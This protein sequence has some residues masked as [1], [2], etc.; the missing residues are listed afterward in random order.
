MALRTHQIVSALDQ[1]RDL[2]S[3]FDWSLSQKRDLYLQA[4]QKL[5]SWSSLEILEKVSNHPF[6]GALA[7]SEW[8]QDPN[9]ALPFPVDWSNHE[10]SHHWVTQTIQNIPTFAVDGSQ[11]ILDKDISLPIALIQIGWY[12]NYHS[13]EGIYEKNV[14][15]DILTPQELDAQH[16]GD[17]RSSRIHFR[18]FEMEIN[19]LVDYIQSSQKKN[20]LN[21]LAFFDGALVA[22]FAEPYDPELQHAYVQS[23]LALLRTSELARI[24]IVAYI[25]TTYTRDLTNLLRHVFDLPEALQIHDA[26]LLDPY[27]DWGERTPFFLCARSGT[28]AG[29]QGILSQY[30]EMRH[31]VGFV[32]LKTNDNYP[33]RLELPAW[34]FEAGLLDWVID[35]VRCEVIIGRGYPYVIETADHVALLRA[36]DRS[37]FLRIL[38]D[39]SERENLPLRL[40]RKMISKMRRRRVR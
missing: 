12:E 16:S 15:V 34:I 28:Q 31:R 30:Q 21:C 11:L 20:Q 26:Q 32:Y 23:L 40:S 24:P 8:D 3:A 19:R 38:Q 10:E 27:L 9:W 35:I 25:D 29:Q 36:E 17:L 7:T 14:Q 6:P 2:F 13:I 4:M 39:W 18:R 22:T 33:V 1:K 37:T 5:T